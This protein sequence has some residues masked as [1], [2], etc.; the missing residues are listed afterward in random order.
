MKIISFYLPQFHT[1]PENDRW[2]GK[3]FTEWTSV[4]SAKS[5]YRGHIQPRIPLNHNYYDL[6]DPETVRWQSALAKKYGIYGFCYY[7]YWFD[8]KMLMNKPMELM[9]QDQNIDLPFCICWA[10]ENWTKEW[11]K[12]S[13]E[14][15][16]AQT[17]GN[18]EDW[19]D[20]FYY[21]LPFL[22][23]HRY[24]RIDEKPV[25]VIYRP[26]LIPT[27][28]EMLEFWQEMAVKAELPGLTFMYQQ[29]AFKHE[30]DKGGK[31]FDY[32]IEYQ[33]NL[34]KHQQ[35]YTLPIMI[36]KT[37]N[38]LFERFNIK[39]VRMSCLGYGY[40]DAWKR[41]LKWKPRDQ[42]MLPGA[43]VN[44][45]NTPRYK[46][47]G[48]FYTGVTPEKFCMYL[49]SQIEHAKITYKKDFIFMF[50]WNEWGEGGYLEPDEQN[51]Y[52]MLEAVRKALTDTGEF[53]EYPTY[54]FE[55]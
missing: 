21:L 7:H 36:K 23:D 28:Q 8:G 20:H 17:Y 15:L 14:V 44:W 25:I 37:L 51:G 46:A 16:I 31:L 24:I 1:F 10:N 22:K 53:P 6:T 5:L 49:K 40:D 29:S 13:K 11:A 2:W 54:S 33:P 48:S 30:T 9:L 45:D 52:A 43:F 3:G 26:E 42:K 27:L 18:K 4:K 38:L 19:K 35:Q 32:A 55:E 47:K 41:I 50:A 39:H 12:K 34:V